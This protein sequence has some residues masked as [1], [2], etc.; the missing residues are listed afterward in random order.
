[1]IRCFEEKDRQKFFELSHALHNSEAVLFEVGDESFT[2]TFNLVMENSPYAAAY[3]I[4]EENEAAGF[5][6]LTFSYSNEMGGLIVWLEELYILEKFRNKG[7]GKE[8]LEFLKNEYKNKAAYI[9]LEVT[10]SNEGAK[11]L[12]ENMGYKELLYKQMLVKL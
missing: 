8:F 4:E 7:L 2:K 9:R 12:Y 11:R 6:L 3:M 1:L 10:D 5:G